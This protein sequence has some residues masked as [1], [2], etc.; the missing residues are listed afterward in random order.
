MANFTELH[1]SN[2]SQDPK[3]SQSSR[4]SL[5]KENML[6]GAGLV[7]VTAVSGVFLL[8]TNGCSKGS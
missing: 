6:F 5:S 3:K 4:T 1:L 7:A 2:N 8:I